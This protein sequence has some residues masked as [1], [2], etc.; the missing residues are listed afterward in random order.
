MNRSVWQILFL[1]SPFA[2]D[3]SARCL[4]GRWDTLRPRA[5]KPKLKK[6]RGCKT[7]TQT[8][9][10][11]KKN[12]K[13]ET[14]KA[15]MI[16]AWLEL[17]DQLLFPTQRLK[18][19][20][21]PTFVCHTDS[22]VRLH[23][24]QCKHW[25]FDTSLFSESMTSINLFRWAASGVLT[26]PCS[27][28]QTLRNGLLLV[29]LQCLQW[30]WLWRQTPPGFNGVALSMGAKQTML[31]LATS[32]STYVLYPSFSAAMIADCDCLLSLSQATFLFFRG[33]CISF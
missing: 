19:L 9:I 11:Q 4:K 18:W 6:K 31:P 3:H 23:C 2:T 21:E 5:A 16:D 15:I 29:A 7:N 1:V 32:C 13:V 8:W 30:P 27:N 26:R 22:V 10:W 28:W 20:L 14:S 17:L 24:L 33:V 12:L 25:C